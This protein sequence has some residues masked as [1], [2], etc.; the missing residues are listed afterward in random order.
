M[1]KELEI[2]R[3]KGYYI[4]VNNTGG[5]IK[6]D[7][8]PFVLM[9]EESPAFSKEYE[10]VDGGVMIEKEFLPL[11][12]YLRRLAILSDIV[13]QAKYINIKPEL[14]FYFSDGKEVDSFR[15]AL[16]TDLTKEDLTKET[17]VYKMLNGEEVPLEEQTAIFRNFKMMKGLMYG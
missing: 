5:K 8:P 11:P 14:I 17:T 7:Y 1:K 6:V 9:E 4:K 15:E 16:P 12:F 2:L 13:S 3:R 10:L